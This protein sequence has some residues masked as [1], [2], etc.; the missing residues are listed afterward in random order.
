MAQIKKIWENLSKNEKQKYSISNT[1][2][3]DER[4]K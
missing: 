1:W 4:Q 3:D 2:Q